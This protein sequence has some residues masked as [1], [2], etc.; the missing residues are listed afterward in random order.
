MDK[1]FTYIISS[2]DR[3]NTTLP[4][5]GATLHYDIDFG[6]FSEQYEDYMCEV[7]S[8]AL[9]GGTPGTATYLMFCAEYLAENGYFCKNKLSPTE[10]IL[11]IILLSAA[12]DAFIQSDGGNVRYRINKCRV[13]K[14]ITFFFLTTD[15]TTAIVGTD[16]N[17]A[18]VESRWL[19]TLKMIPIVK[20]K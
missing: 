20:G 4:A 18:A 3:T 13:Q 9:T 19:L 10:C 11:S 1:S 12:Q 2:R 6:G 15:F 8:Y 17:I 14:Q 5:K 16:L 7:I